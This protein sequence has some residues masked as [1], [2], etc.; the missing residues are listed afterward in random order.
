MKG[1][2]TS[3]MGQGKGAGKDRA[4]EA[5]QNAISSPLLDAS[6]ENATGIIWN[7]TGPKDLSLF[8]VI[9]WGKRGVYIWEC[10]FEGGGGMPPASMPKGSATSPGLKTS[11]CLR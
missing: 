6:I 10:V 2:G 3:L 5:A 9:L 4:R 11:A 7:I 1:S 8:E